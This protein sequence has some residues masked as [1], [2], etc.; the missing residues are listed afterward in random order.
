LTIFSLL[1]TLFLKDILLDVL[2]LFD[3][4]GLPVSD[5]TLANS[6]WLYIWMV[7]LLERLQ[8]VMA[9]AGVASRRRCEEMIV[10][11]MV[12]VNG[13][14]ITELG[15]KVDPAEDKIVVGGETLLLQD[16]K[17]YLI[18]Y[19]PRGY[20]ST[21][22]DEKGRKNVIDLLDGFEGRVYPVG[23][24]DYDSEGLLL[25]TNDGDL[26]YALTHPKHRVPKTYL[27]RVHGIPTDFKLEQMAKGLLL[28]DGPTAPARVRLADI[29]RGNALLE[30][31]LYEG[32]NRQ[33]RRMCEHIGHPVLRLLR[34]H[35][36]NISLD[37]LRPGK[38]RYMNKREL[39]RLKE[40]A[41]LDNES[42]EILL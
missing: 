26:A 7:I 32:R 30:I 38:Y 3:F 11:G 1:F 40:I 31:T 22:R 36:G 6:V 8:K 9:R 34:T 20:V 21:L 2:V 18:L 35:V 10:A 37:G 23:R 33:V 39:A 25:L 29:K 4:K 24:L 12:K 41:G 16:K 42:S 28:E 5:M 19:K 27:A 17:H 15:T 13:K 14:V